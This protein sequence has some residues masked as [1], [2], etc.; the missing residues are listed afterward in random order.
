MNKLASRFFVAGDKFCDTVTA[1]DG[2]Q[3]GSALAAVIGQVVGGRPS[4]AGE[5][6]GD[7][8]V[9]ALEDDAPVATD[10]EGSPNTGCLIWTEVEGEGERGTVSSSSV[11]MVELQSDATV[12][13]DSG[14]PEKHTKRYKK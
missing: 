2:G 11:E 5:P 1:P 10:V 12:R 6:A 8:T 7:V 14:R 13:L 9:G 4:V 3:I